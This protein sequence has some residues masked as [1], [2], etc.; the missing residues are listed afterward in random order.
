GLSDD[1]IGRML[2]DSLQHAGTDMH[3]RSLREAQVEAQALLDAIKAALANDADLLGSD[4]RS[5]ID[6][7]LQTL[8]Q[9]LPGND[10]DQLRRATEA[11][12]N[13]T[14]D[15]AAR[16]MDKQINKALSGRKLTTLE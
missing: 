10:A 1:D 14:T 11:L 7:A 9:Q 2:Q 3:A 12:N 5:T 8:Q 13:A 15:F 4:E 16:R 6:Q